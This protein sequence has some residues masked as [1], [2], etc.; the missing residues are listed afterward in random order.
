MV[1]FVIGEKQR[2]IDANRPIT[3]RE[4][5]LMLDVYKFKERD[6]GLCSINDRTIA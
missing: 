3:G 6:E 2:I 4:Y 5:K 1:Q